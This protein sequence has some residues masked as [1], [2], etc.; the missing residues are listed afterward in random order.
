MGWKVIIRSYRW[1]AHWSFTLLL[2]ILTYKYFVTMSSPVT[3]L[4][5]SWTQSRHV[6]QNQLIKKPLVIPRIITTCNRYSEVVASFWWY[7]CVVFDDNIVELFKV[8][9]L[10]RMINSCFGFKLNFSRCFD[11]SDDKRPYDLRP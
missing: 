1:L 3:S 5:Y 11:N 7:E 9:V 2:S 4:V 8:N 10:F 6:S